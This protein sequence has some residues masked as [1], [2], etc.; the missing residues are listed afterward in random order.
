MTPLRLPTPVQENVWAKNRLGSAVMPYLEWPV[1]GEIDGRSAFPVSK[2]LGA[3]ARANDGRPGGTRSGSSQWPA[4]ANAILQ[5]L[6]APLHIFGLGARHLSLHP[7]SRSAL[8][9]PAPANQATHGAARQDLAPSIDLA[10]AKSCRSG[11][12]PPFTHPRPAGSACPPHRESSWR[13][14]RWL[15]RGRVGPPGGKTHV[16]AS[17]DG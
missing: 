2:R 9:V 13:R 15:R 10:A 14:L 6:A 4:R 1:R 16:V 3:E 8:A 12:S 7:I 11:S 17:A 5:P